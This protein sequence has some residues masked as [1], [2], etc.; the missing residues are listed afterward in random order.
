ML[1]PFLV[2]LFLISIWVNSEPFVFLLVFTL[3]VSLFCFMTSLPFAIENGAAL[4]GLIAAMIVIGLGTGGIKSNVSPLIADQYTIT[5]P[6]VKTLKSGERV[7]V[8]PPTTIQSIFMMF[9]MCINVGSL[10][11]I[12]TTEMELHEFVGSLSFALLLFLYCHC[13]A[14]FWQQV[15]CQASSH[16]LRSSRYF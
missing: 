16:G 15:L 13:F 12:A 5:K 11:A 2:P 10:S 1:L 9:Y 3:L 7:I 8:D 4:G 14:D 6:Y